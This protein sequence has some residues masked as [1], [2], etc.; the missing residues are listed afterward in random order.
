[1]FSK[2]DVKKNL[3]KFTPMSFIK[4]LVF[5]TF[6]ILNYFFILSYNF[7]NVIHYFIY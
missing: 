3:K 7:F 4:E 1:M 2:I 5:K 6:T